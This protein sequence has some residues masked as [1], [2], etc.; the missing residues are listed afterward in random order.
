MPVRAPHAPARLA[1]TAFELFAESGFDRVNL[2]AIAAR[3]GVT[4][5]SIYHHYGSKKDVI[6]ASCRHYYRNWHRTVQSLT[7][8]LSDPLERLT[9]VLS[10]SVKTCLI[11]EQNRMFTSSSSRYK[12]TRSFANGKGQHK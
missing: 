2:D 8:Q 4:K 6:L 1:E 11:D 3:A 10:S 12:R 9:A 7:A 5:G